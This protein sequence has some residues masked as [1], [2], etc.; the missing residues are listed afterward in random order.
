VSGSLTV[1][2]EAKDEA[3]L[4]FYRKHGFM[5]LGVE[6]NRVYLPMGTVERLL[7]PPR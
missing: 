7:V 2:A 5:Q 3:A 4:G 1:V 6:P